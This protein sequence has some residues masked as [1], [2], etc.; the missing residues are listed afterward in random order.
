MDIDRNGMV[1]FCR[2]LIKIPSQPGREK[3][4]IR[5]AQEELHV[6]G[7]DE[8][9]CDDFGSL[10]GIVRNG[11]GPTVI[12]DAHVD[13]VG[14]EPV[15]EWTRDPLGGWI[16]EEKIYGRGSVDMKGAAAAIVYGLASLIPRKEEYRGRII[17]SLS[18]LEEL[19]EG[20]ALGNIIDGYGA[21]FVVIGEPSNLR[22]IRGQRGRAEIMITT[23]G[24][25]AHSSS[26]H[27]GVNAVAKMGGLIRMM[28]EMELPEHEF[29][30]RGVQ[31]LTDIIS[32]PYPT[33][34]TIPAS[35]RATFDR[36]LVVGENETSIAGELHDLI[37]KARSADPQLQALAEIVTIE[38]AA[39]TGH[40]FTF[41]KFI[42]AWEMP[43]D[44]DLVRAAA[45]A[46]ETVGLD[47]LPADY[48]RFCT[49][50][51]WSCVHSGVPTIGFGPGDGALAHGID[52]YVE[53]GQLDSAARGYAA[54]ALEMLKT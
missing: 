41:R 5:R 2:D 48:Y 50:G 44:H 16:E 24:V 18:T 15:G 20:V 19:C 34:S 26:P 10:I 27:L 36:R 6:L 25:P 17:V 51:S 21:D 35:C 43:E 40:R 39:Y 52:E 1:E 31:A 32:V 12:F 49:N 30:G 4:V 3:A 38:C 14:V 46:L 13:T 22:L 9:D 47:G 11:D 28:D 42:P 45:R 8:C 54:I 37:E 7:F 23:Q 53:I 33:Q 29:L